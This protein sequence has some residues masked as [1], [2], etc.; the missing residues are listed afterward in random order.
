MTT[1]SI[2]T[3]LTQEISITISIL[4]YS[5]MRISRRNHK[6]GHLH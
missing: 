1:E 4:K 2:E 5:K 6:K 3:Y